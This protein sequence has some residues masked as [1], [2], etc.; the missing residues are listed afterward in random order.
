MESYDPAKNLWTSHPSLKA[1]KGSMAS[2]TLNDKIF[3]IGGGN[4]HDCLSDVEMYDLQVGRWIPTRSM[5]KKVIFALYM[6][7]CIF[8]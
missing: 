5:Q 6:H 2:A 4:G 8:T 1:K 7:V 3:A